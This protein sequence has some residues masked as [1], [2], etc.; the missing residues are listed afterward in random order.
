VTRYDVEA[1]AIICGAVGVIA[2]VTLLAARLMG[3]RIAGRHPRL[4]VLVSGLTAAAI[5]QA[6]GWTL[7]VIDT[8]RHPGSDWPAMQL[9][10]TMIYTAMAVPIGLAVAGWSLRRGATDVRP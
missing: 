1:I 5:L 3:R 2:V 9:L 10:S 4:A 6:V 8:N 7:F